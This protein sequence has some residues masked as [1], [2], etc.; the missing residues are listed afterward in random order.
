MSDNAH[1][2]LLGADT[3]VGKAEGVVAQHYGVKRRSGRYPW[4][5]GKEPF[6]R[7]GDFLSRVEE[8][9]KKGFKFYDKE[10]GK[11]YNGSTAIAKHF[12]MSSTELRV[13]IALAKNER[14]A[15]LVNRARSLKEDGLGASEIARQMGLPNESSVRSLL[16]EKSAK[17]TNAAMELADSLKEIVDKKKYVDVGSGVEV[18][19]G[20]S[21]QKLNEALYIM[22]REGYGV[23]GL[24][25]RQQT[26]L[27]NQTIIQ[28][29]CAKGI[30]YKEAYKAKDRGEVQSLKDYY[31]PDDGTNRI[32]SSK[33]AYPAS[34]DS[35]RLMV[36]FGDTGTGLE[37]DGTIYIRP[38]CKDLSL[39]NSRF[40]QVRILVD[41]SRYLKGMAIYK[42]DL[43]KG[44]DVVFNTNKPES[45]GKLGALK[46]IEHDEND[47]NN[48]F[49]STVKANGQNY[50]IDSDGTKKL[51]LINKL[52]EQG[53]WNNQDNSHIASQFLSKQSGKMVRQQ[54]DLTYAEK[55]SEFD[56][57]M[58]LNNRTL[59]RKKLMEFADKCDSDSA[60][61]DASAL[62]R[63]KWQVLIP[64]PSLKDNECYA[65]NFKDGEKLALVRYP[66]GG[67]FEIPV[68]TVNNK[69]AAAKKLIGPD[70]VDAIGI[71]AKVASVLS[72]ADFDGDTV[73]AIPTNSRVKIR[74][75]KP[76]EG[77]IGF[78]PKTDYKLT[79]GVDYKV[80]KDEFG[81]DK[82]VSMKKGV[83][84]LD[85][86]YTQNQMG[87][88]SNL[89]TDMTIK[90]ADD[91]ELTKAVKHSM[92]VIDA[93][94]HHLDYRQSEADNDIKTLKQKYQ[95]HYVID[96][97]GNRKYKEG[98]STI[99]SRAGS[100][101]DVIKRVGSPNMDIMRKTGE[102][103]Y[104]QSVETF[105]DP[106]TGKER[107]RMQ[108]STAML[109]VKDAN[110]LSSG[111]EI[112][113]YYARYAN[114]LKALARLARKEGSNLPIEKKDPEAAKRYSKEVEELKEALNKVKAN[115]PRERMAQ[116][117]AGSRSDA[118]QNSHPEYS[119]ADMKKIRAQQLQIAR[120]EVG[121]SGK[122]S[123]IKFTD[124]QWE[125]IQHRA[126]S[127]NVVSQL[128]A[129]SDPET[130]TKLA[131][132]RTNTWLTPVN[133]SRIKAMKLSGF[134]IAEIAEAMG[135]SP[136]TISKVLNG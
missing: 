6:Q 9:E 117:I 86:K 68:V 119:K 25:Q 28:T 27:A 94:K 8:L 92:V 3:D 66:H 89:I 81:R 99:I 18:E 59:K 57:L 45:V 49:G 53:D 97:D 115:K 50:Y 104:K 15:Q 122:T 65:P 12:G 100:E 31:V 24:G 96:K 103:V 38:G 44:I 61:L 107:V 121:A 30:P 51:G 130:T 105:I 132:P 118:I 108:K 5:S 76:L 22:Q 16:N 40:A 23:Y 39:G 71:N 4:G 78:D 52:K 136:T 90:G 102:K 17:R 34:L 73:I 7:S 135:K 120:E 54:L 26:N 63:Q 80:V 87:I 62:P 48:P 37:A 47:P 11:T 116:M 55:A 36:N 10:T 77:L 88:V 72:G 2:V 134:T 123:R 35:K 98:A 70:S 128:L 93:A 84:V 113:S 58:K 106:K 43:P 20:V 33:M 114:R 125:A 46:K 101:V 64:V 124:R 1:S 129:A 74:T 14:R 133:E 91:S 19:L 85:K 131:T 32:I 21:K 126:L 56:E 42:N 79:E 111:N 13:Q 83:S 60:D 109:E 67:I 29:V 112:E 110:E 41:N 82:A 69:Q 127:D 75:K 95:G